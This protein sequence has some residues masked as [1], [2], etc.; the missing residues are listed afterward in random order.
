MGLDQSPGLYH[1]TASERSVSV[2]PAQ[3]PPPSPRL[4]TIPRSAETHQVRE[5]HVPSGLFAEIR[6]LRTAAGL[7]PHWTFNG[8]FDE[9]PTSRWRHETIDPTSLM[10]PAL[11]PGVISRLYSGAIDAAVESN[12]SLL[13]GIIAQAVE[14]QIN[15][16]LRV[17]E[18]GNRGRHYRNSTA[19]ESARASQWRNAA[20]ECTVASN[21]GVLSDTVLESDAVCVDAFAETGVCR[22]ECVG[23]TPCYRPGTRRPEENTYSVLWLTANILRTLGVQQYWQSVVPTESLFVNNATRP[24]TW[25]PQTALDGRVP[26]GTVLGPADDVECARLATPTLCETMRECRWDPERAASGPIGFLTACTTRDPDNDLTAL[27][28][29]AALTQNGEG[30]LWALANVGDFAP[31]AIAAQ[32]RSTIVGLLEQPLISERF[33]GI[34]CIESQIAIQLTELDVRVGELSLMTLRD[35]SFGRVAS[36][37]P[38]FVLELALSADALTRFSVERNDAAYGSCYMDYR[39]C[40]LGICIGLPFTGSISRW[41]EGLN[42]QL[43]ARR[44]EVEPFVVR[45]ALAFDQNI[46]VAGLVD[47]FPLNGRADAELIQAAVRGTRLPRIDGIRIRPHVYTLLSAESFKVGGRSPA[48]FAEYVIVDTL[49][50]SFR[51]PTIVRDALRGV[52][53]AALPNANGGLLESQLNRA[54]REVSCALTGFRDHEGNR[55]QV[56]TSVYDPLDCTSTAFRSL[57]GWLGSNWTTIT[58]LVPTY[59]AQHCASAACSPGPSPQNPYVCDSPQEAIQLDEAGFA[60]VDGALCQPIDRCTA[61]RRSV[62]LQIPD[63]PVV[64]NNFNPSYDCQGSPAGCLRRRASVTEGELQPVAELVEGLIRQALSRAEIRPLDESA[65]GR[66]WRNDSVSLFEETEGGLSYLGRPADVICGVAI[67]GGNLRIRTDRFDPTEGNSGLCGSYLPQTPR[68]RLREVCGDGVCSSIELNSCSC[69]MDCTLYT[70]TQGRI[71]YG[72]SASAAR[73]RFPVNSNYVQRCMPNADC[74]DAACT[75]EEAFYGVCHFEA[76]SGLPTSCRSQFDAVGEAACGDDLCNGSEDTLS[77]ARDCPSGATCGDGVCMDWMVEDAEGLV[78]PLENCLSC[79]TDCGV[80]FGDCGPGVCDPTGRNAECPCDIVT[81]CGD[82]VCSPDEASTGL[83]SG[84]YCAQDCPCGDGV[85]DVSAGE[86]SGNCPVDC[87]CGDGVCTDGESRLNCAPDCAEPFDGLCGDCERV[88]RFNWSPFLDRETTEADPAYQEYLQCRRYYIETLGVEAYADCPAFCDGTVGEDCCGNG[89][90]EEPEATAD[91][92]DLCRWDCCG[93]GVCRNGENP[94]NCVA[95]CGEEGF[96]CGDGLCRPD[97]DCIGDDACRED[98]N[99]DPCFALGC[100]IRCQYDPP[101]PRC[102]DGVCT[103]PFYNNGVLTNTVGGESCS[104]CPQDCDGQFGLSCNT[105]GDNF[106]SP[107]ESPLQCPADCALANCGDGVCADDET[108]Q[109]CPADCERCGDRV[110]GVT[111]SPTLCATDCSVCGDCI[112]SDCAVLYPTPGHDQGLCNLS[113]VGSGRDCAADC[114]YCGDTVCQDTEVVASEGG[115]GDMCYEDCG[116][117]GDGICQPDDE[118]SDCVRDCPPTCGNGVCS[119]IEFNEFSCPRDCGI[120]RCGNGRC[121]DHPDEFDAQSLGVHPCPLD[122]GAPFECSP[123]PPGVRPDCTYTGGEPG[124]PF[125]DFGV[126]YCGDDVCDRDYGETGCNCVEDCGPPDLICTSTGFGSTLCLPQ[127][128]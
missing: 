44:M 112:C 124:L 2:Q 30:S 24:P 29:N 32:L 16:A 61:H 73:L 72:E 98:C 100:G 111:E 36:D 45:V 76:M 96:Y 27:G 86:S 39:W 88:S 59:E 10:Y 65:L 77:C 20:T 74:S 28:V 9:S 18:A 11:P 83:S 106:C 94:F 89:V 114:T 68:V 81:N 99:I 78:R 13:R 115:C 51:L 126:A 55:C 118:E 5:W 12:D 52:I 102:G 57:E 43:D 35:A 108:R 119:T 117:C 79:A 25:I 103:G 120:E 80:C 47:R 82:G 19:D 110:C 22:A 67:E 69:D 37:D 123:A 113:R 62:P 7:Y 104:T 75:N 122:C 40:A 6:T 84:T 48:A 63:G 121:V 66:T 23:E 41:I 1:G 101:G 116:T 105:C 107:A 125:P 53:A 64:R 97:E 14:G 26:R 17:I 60:R 85:C 71:F 87:I 50:R 38:A 8:G 4:A 70:E 128:Y 91:W 49:L 95:D 93:D 58:N 34:P 109:N 31:P 92:G 90:C 42:E 15:D 56:R 33:G 21:C 46:E 127:C 54:L 3:L